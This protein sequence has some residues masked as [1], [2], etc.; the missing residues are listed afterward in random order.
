MK[1]F[2]WKKISIL[3]FSTVIS[4]GFRQKNH[5]KIRQNQKLFRRKIFKISVQKKRQNSSN[6]HKNS[7]NEK[8]AQ[9]SRFIVK[10]VI[11]SIFILDASASILARVY[12]SLFFIQ[13]LFIYYLI[14]L[15]IFIPLYLYFFLSLIFIS[16]LFIFSLLFI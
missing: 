13:I 5:W 15:Y 3:I 14:F 9:T 7:K 1:S 10:R 16:F 4:S 12:F 8:S 11:S 6:F 2:F